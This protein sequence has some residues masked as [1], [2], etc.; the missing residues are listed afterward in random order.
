MSNTGVSI[1]I[2]KKGEDINPNL[3]YDNKEWK[4]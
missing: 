1:S 2:G 4:D 3:K